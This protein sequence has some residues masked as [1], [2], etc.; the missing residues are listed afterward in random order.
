MPVTQESGAAHANNVLQAIIIGTGFAGLGMAIALQK[1]GIDRFLI[2]EKADDVG[3][4]WRDNSY[5]GAAC[6]VPSHL[7]SFSFYPN[8][9]W[10]RKFAPQGE[11]LTYLK[12]C[13]RQFGLRKYVRF[14]SEVRAAEFDEQQQN[15]RVLLKDGTELRSQLLITAMGQL[16]RPAIPAI[17]GQSS[18][19]GKAFHSARWDHAFD[20]TG[21]R[22]AVIGTGASAIQFVPA[23]A[24]RV[25]SMEVF[26]R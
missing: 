13:A 24:A 20:L 4:V 11:I 21:K 17:E 12:D 19:Q 2:L 18:F 14:G 10:T 9:N 25:E 23:I 6:D 22:V 16:S 15:W 3:G 8:P 7:Y 5:P 26:Q 1:Q